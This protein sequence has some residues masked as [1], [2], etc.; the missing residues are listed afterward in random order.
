MV[1]EYYRLTSRE[2]RRVDKDLFEVVEEVFD[3]A[4]VRALLELVRKKVIYEV[5][6][7]V[8][9]GKEARVY[10]GKSF[11][12][13]DIAIKIYL[14]SSAEF[15]KGITKYLEADPRFSGRVPT[16]TRKLYS[17]WAKKEFSNYTR[18][19]EAGVSVPRPLAVHENILVMSFIGHDGVPAPLL[20]DL[21]LDLGE[22]ERIFKK[23]LEDL[24]K[25]FQKARLVHGDL[26]E[27]NVMIWEGTHYIIDVSQA[28]TLDHPNAIEYLT[29]DLANLI[30]FFDKRGLPT[31][32][33]SELLDYISTQQD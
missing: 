14:T 7:V 16:S 27:Y 31:P 8:S 1:D 29:R 33:L 20:K 30:K 32:S 12:K 19:Y 21:D 22:L 6:G 3:A 2:P 15:R 25:M 26:S 9:A 13:K 10:W 24:R 11:E 17:L 28:V 23:L 4:T 18:M 5:K